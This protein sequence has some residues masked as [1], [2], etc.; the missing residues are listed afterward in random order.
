[1]TPELAPGEA[2][3][4]DLFVKILLPY[5]DAI[6]PLP[7]L[8]F[9]TESLLAVACYYI[10][11]DSDWMLKFM[12]GQL[13]AINTTMA[14]LLH[15]FPPMYNFYTSM[16]FLP[17]KDFWLYATGLAL[18]AGGVGITFAKTQVYAAWCLVAVLIIM[19]PGNLACVFMEHPRNVVAGGS[20]VKAL[21]RLPLQIP[22]I[23][24]AFWFTSPPLPTAM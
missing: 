24:W 2:G 12:L 23:A 4:A 18:I 10:Y 21:V 19:F 8:F 3:S 16:I 7:F 13:L 9:V 14:G 22:F 5:K 1:M 15:F 17:L 11:A 20:M 6:T